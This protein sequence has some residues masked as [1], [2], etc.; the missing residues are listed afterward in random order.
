MTQ[1]SRGRSRRPTRKIAPMMALAWY[2]PEQWERLRAISAD[3]DRLEES[4][5]QW[6]EV[7]EQTIEQLQR[8]GVVVERIDV[9][10]EELVAWCQA[11]GLTLDGAARAN[12]AAEKLRRSHEVGEPPDGGE[13]ES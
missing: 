2:R 13:Q 3:R 8:E 6:R 7:T 12:F 5:E 1:R 9:D 10:V 11:N 4:Y